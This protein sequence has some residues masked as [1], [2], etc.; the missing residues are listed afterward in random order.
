MQRHQD[1]AER[2]VE[3]VEPLPHLTQPTQETLQ[4]KE[5]KCPLKISGE[6]LF[7][8]K[9]ETSCNVNLEINKM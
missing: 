5:V 7:Y 8:M 4:W 6:Y 9:L 2:A 1:N 3:Y